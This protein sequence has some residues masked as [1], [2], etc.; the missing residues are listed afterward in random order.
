MLVSF[1]FSYGICSVSFEKKKEKKKKK[2]NYVRGAKI[3]D[4]TIIFHESHAWHGFAISNESNVL[5]F[6][7]QFFN[8]Y[9]YLNVFFKFGLTHRAC[10]MWY[11]CYNFVK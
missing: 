11:I 7:F 2:V 10:I 8:C 3:D 4:R 5:Y 9:I 1:L 6:A